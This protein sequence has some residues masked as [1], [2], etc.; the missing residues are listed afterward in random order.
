MYYS[1]AD[2]KRDMENHIKSGWKSHTCAMGA[3][4]AG[5]SSSQD[6]LVVYEK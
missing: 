2:A 4:M 1:M 3:Y 5:F 6:V